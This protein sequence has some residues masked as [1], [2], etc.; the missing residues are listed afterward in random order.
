MSFWIILTAYEVVWFTALIGAGRGLNWPGVV[1]AATFIAWRLAVS[2]QR[3]VETRLALVAF[4]FGLSFEGICVNAGLVRYAAPWPLACAPLWLIALWVVFALTMLPLFGYL[5]AR[6]WLAALF[7]AL[8][9]PL[10]YLAAARGWHVVVFVDPA[11][12]GLLAVAIGW[13]IAMPLLCTLARRWMHQ[14]DVALAHGSA[15]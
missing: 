12:H 8:G 6:P 9:G 3:S 5:H 7:G 11:W 13:G 15:P 2:K 10:A 14:G 4:V 1:A